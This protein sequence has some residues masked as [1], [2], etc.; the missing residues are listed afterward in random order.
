MNEVNN[1]SVVIEIE[2]MGTKLLFTGD[3]DSD[4]WAEFLTDEYD[5]IK[6]SHQ[7]TTK[8]NIKL[9]EKAKGRTLL[10]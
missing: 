7:G 2:Y 1:A 9:L 3:S 5:L 4:S 6:I 8:P 10:I